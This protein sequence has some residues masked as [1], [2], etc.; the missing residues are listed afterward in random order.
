MIGK[1]LKINPYRQHQRKNVGGN[2]IDE[3]DLL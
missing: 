2:L 1:G 3:R